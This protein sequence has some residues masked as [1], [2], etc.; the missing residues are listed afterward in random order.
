MRRVLCLLGVLLF[1]PPARAETT[2]VRI[3]QQ[4]STAFLQF[5]VMK[6][7]GLIEKHA[8]ALG[9]PNV[10]VSFATFN[11]SDAQNQALLSG[12]V[13]IVSGGQP[14]LLVLWAKTWGTAQ[15]VRGISGLARVPSL[16]NS[17][18]PAVHSIRD[19]TAVD[20]IAMPGIKMSTQAVLLQ[21]AAAKEWGDAAYDKLDALTVSVAPADATAGL[22]SGGG[23]FNAAFTVP[24]FQDMQLRDPAVHTV[25]DSRDVIGEM[26]ASVAWTNKSFHDANPKVYRAIVEAV[27]EASTFVTE[28]RREAVEYYAADTSAKVDV[29]AVTAIVSGPGITYDAAPVA[30][31]K[32]ATFMARVGKWKATPASWK[33]L[34]WPEIHD[35]NGS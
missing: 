29:D 23:S 27:K 21:M 7:Q 13:D 11:G 25:L 12:A 22:L 10:K 18:N 17:R 26:S 34:F 4:T 6:H 32:W 8:A 30:S 5:N 14:G 35:L 31:M 19:L 2:E 1:M 28:H 16:L 3:A 20:R 24:P 9:V 15:E 33:D